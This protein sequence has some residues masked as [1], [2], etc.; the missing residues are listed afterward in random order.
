MKPASIAAHG[1]ELVTLAHASGAAVHADAVQ[2][3][4]RLPVDLDRLALD[5]LSLSGHKMHGPQ[6]VGAVYAR[7]SMPLHPLIPGGGQEN[8]RRGGTENVPG[9]A[10]LGAAAE[11]AAAALAEGRSPRALRDR[12]EHELLSA[13]P[14]LVIHGQ[15]APRLDNTASI[16]FPGLDA[17]GLL[18]LL[19]Q[20]GIAC[21]GG[22]AC[23]SAALHPSHVLE[24]MGLSARHAAGTVRFSF[25]RMNTE[26]EIDA[27]LPLILGAVHKLRAL[28][29]GPAVL[30]A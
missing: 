10:G 16:A 15:N 22:S 1:A 7:G 18:I 4:G 26:A 19:D 14:D 23:H 2:A 3:V 27:A 21:S 28:Q 5:Y 12:L 29:A 11:L 17:A 30:I 8:G 20:R 6:G 13:L 24:A 25:S 9:I